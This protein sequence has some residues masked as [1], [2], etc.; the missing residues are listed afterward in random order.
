MAEFTPGTFSAQ[1][2]D[3]ARGF[4]R[5]GVY[6]EQLEE[7][8]KFHRA[9]DIFIYQSELLFANSALFFK[10]LFKFL[11]F[12]D[13]RGCKKQAL[14]A[15]LPRKNTKTPKRDLEPDE[16]DALRALQDFYTPWNRQLGQFIAAN[17]NPSST[18]LNLSM[19]E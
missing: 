4:L 16:R 9:E 15:P 13:T 10:R 8:F 17:V 19:W 5:R 7:L 11:G 12:K 1:S 2:D 6:V 3:Q 18:F 14:S